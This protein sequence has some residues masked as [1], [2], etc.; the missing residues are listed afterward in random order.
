MTKTKTI[1]YLGLKGFPFGTAEVQ[2]QLQISKAILNAE[3]RVLVINQKGTHLLNTIKK[4]NIGTTGSYEGIDYIYASGTPLYVSNFFI[5]NLLKAIGW[6]NELIII[7]YHAFNK[8]LSCIIVCTSSLTKLKYLWCVTRITRTRLVYDYVEYFSSLEDRTIREPSNKMT[9]DKIFFNYTDALIIISPYLVQH[10]KR[11]KSNKPFIMVP[12]IMDFE[13]FSMIHFKPK[14]SN[15]FLYC[16]SVQYID[17]IKFIIE[18]YRKSNSYENGVSLILVVN[19]PMAII[20]KIRDFI[21]EDRTIQILSGL[22]YENLVGYYKNAKALLIPLQDNLQDK[23]RFPFKISEYTAS[24][25][26]IITSDSGAIVQF[27]EDGKNALLA[28]TGDIDDFS[29]KLNFVLENPEKAEQIGLN[30]YAIGE[31]YFNYKN[32]TST[33]RELILP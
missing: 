8:N 5:R 18:A 22:S 9:F 26:P 1:L 21:T 15:Y 27:F 3:T 33:L 7:L 24:A 2:R 11:M 17:V 13:K 20:S 30:G 25:R 19:G 16:G 6:L 23:A 12:P 14:V 10:I 31:H 4:E 28:K 29:T 32:Y